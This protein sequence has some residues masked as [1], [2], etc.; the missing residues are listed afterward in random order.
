MSKIVGAL[1]IVMG[2]TATQA[3]AQSI[4]KVTGAVGSV[5]GGVTSGLGVTS[6]MASPSSTGPSGLPAGSSVGGNLP[7]AIDFNAAGRNM[8]LRGAAGVGD[9]RGNFK[10]GLGIPF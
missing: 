10:A 9:D 3:S 1:A 2:L 7:G 8:Q 6:N 4:S 5:T